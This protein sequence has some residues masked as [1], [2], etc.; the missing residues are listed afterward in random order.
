MM[1]KLSLYELWLKCLNI[2]KRITNIAYG[3]KFVFA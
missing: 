2:V 1:K 3:E